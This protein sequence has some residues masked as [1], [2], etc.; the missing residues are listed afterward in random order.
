LGVLIGYAIGRTIDDR[1]WFRGLL[2]KI[3][4]RKEE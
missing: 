3:L 4:P 2:E 1:E